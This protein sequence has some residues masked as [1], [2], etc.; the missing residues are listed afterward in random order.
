MNLCIDIG[1]TRVKVATFEQEELCRLEF[2]P[3]LSSEILTSFFENNAITAAITASV[4]K[5]NAEVTDYLKKQVHYVKL[6]HTTPLPITN[7]YSTPETLGR[8]RIAVSVI[9]HE[10]FPDNPSLVIDAGTCITYDFT[11]ADGIY[12][13]GAIAP[14]MY[15]KFRAMHTFTAKLPLV[16]PEQ[17]VPLTGDTT[18]RSMQSGAIWGTVAEIDGII[19]QY[20][21]LY[22]DLKVFM[23]GGDA[24]FFETKL[25]SKIFVR[26]NLVL[27][28]LNKILDYNVSLLT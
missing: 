8:D 26:P 24:R 9:A 13:G 25:K 22:P 19:D 10:L 2:F 17:E 6:D 4:R 11:D 20:K 7:A 15:M 16:Q 1:N 21:T 12:H 23:T 27:E 18:E 5:D 28:G 14:G 3:K